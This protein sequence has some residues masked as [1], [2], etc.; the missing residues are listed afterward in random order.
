MSNKLTIAVVGCSFT[1]GDGF[2]PETLDDYIYPSLVARKFMLDCDNLAVSGASNHMI[3]MISARA[4]LSKKYELVVCQWTALNRL[5]L[6]PGPDA[7]YYT[8][9]DGKSSYDYRDIHLTSHDKRSLEDKILLLNH[10]YQNIL[11]LID[12]VNILNELAKCNGIKIAHVN[13]LVPWQ[14]D[15]ANSTTINFELLSDYTKEMLDFV[16]RDDAEIHT[17]LQ[18]LQLKFSTLDIENWVNI[19]DSFQHN[20]IDV[21]PQGHHPGIKSH[22]IMADKLENYLTQ[23]II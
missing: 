22:Q 23:G 2:D 17:S 11:D 7:W 14:S 4:I 3:F 13:G 21:A 15:L 12:Y 20:T 6:S 8:T 9:G 10:D 19:F 1:A 16:N 18:K 5:W